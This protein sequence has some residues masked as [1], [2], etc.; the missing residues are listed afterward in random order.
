M[1]TEEDEGTAARKSEE[2]GVPGRGNIICKALRCKRGGMSGSGK[3]PG[4]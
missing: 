3:R 4:C 2:K 1:Q